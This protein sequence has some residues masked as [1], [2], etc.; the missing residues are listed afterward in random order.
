MHM[1]KICCIA[2]YLLPTCVD[3]FCDHHQGGVTGVLKIQ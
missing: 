2:Y 1:Y 3:C